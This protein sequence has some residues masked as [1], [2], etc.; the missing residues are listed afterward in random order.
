MKFLA[1]CLCPFRYQLRGRR[2]LRLKDSSYEAGGVKKMK[3][4]SCRQRIAKRDTAY[5][6]DK[7]V[8][9]DKVSV[10]QNIVLYRAEYWDV[11]MKIEEEKAL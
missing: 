2:R 1:G 10:Y 9:A 11:G 5:I 4:Y 7:Y 6:I 3:K 8:T